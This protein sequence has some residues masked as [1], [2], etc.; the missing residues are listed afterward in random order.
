MDDVLSRNHEPSRAQTLATT[1]PPGTYLAH[2][3][4][5]TPH[6]MSAQSHISSLLRNAL[7]IVLK[8]GFPLCV[9]LS[10]RFT[11]F[12]FLS[13]IFFSVLRLRR[14]NV[15]ANAEGGLGGK[16]ESGM[17]S[18]RGREMFDTFSHRKV[19]TLQAPNL[20][21]V[22]KYPPYSVSFTSGEGRVSDAD[23][24]TTGP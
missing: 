14:P 13:I 8:P 11:P 22:A 6:R 2:P 17:G 23:G 7:A 4:Q 20:D 1:S 5:G 3:A 24:A 16:G 18:T 19:L 9:D 21:V 15:S 10:F 12:K